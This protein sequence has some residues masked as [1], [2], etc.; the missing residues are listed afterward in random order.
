MKSRFLYLAVF[1]VLICVA[2]SAQVVDERDSS[3]DQPPPDERTAAADADGAEGESQAGAEP[4]AVVD[5]IVQR[6]NT[7]REKQGRQPVEPDDQLTEAAQY[8]ADY[9]ARTGRYGH[10]ADSKRPSERAAAH[11]YA[12][13]LVSEN[14]AYQFN[15][16]GFESNALAEKFVTGWRE[17][18]GHRKNMLDPDVQH[19]GVAVAQADNGTW[20]AVQMFGRPESARIEFKITNAGDRPVRYRIG[21]ERFT[22]DPRWTRTHARCRP[23]QVVFGAKAGDEAGD[24]EANGSPDEDATVRPTDGAAYEVTADPSGDVRVRTSDEG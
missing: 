1:C 15:S 16:A 2:A 24:A 11:G 8:F 5:A 18:P 13:C 14:I 19:T 12:F 22:I 3:T 10:T 7:F 20:Y 6:T 9:M 23:A 4:A 21:D 17:S